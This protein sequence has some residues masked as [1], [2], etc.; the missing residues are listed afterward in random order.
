MSSQHS[1][2]LQENDTNFH[3]AVNFG[4]EHDKVD[5]ANLAKW[6][7]ITIVFVLILIATGFQLYT[8]YTY[9]TAEKQ[10]ISTTY[11]N[12]DTYKIQVNTR[13][14]SY[15]IADDSKKLYHIPIDK[16]IEITVNDY[17]KK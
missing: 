13:L 11:E 7:V 17:S 2:P 5:V 14:N 1:N 16:A 4:A 9:T 3:E 12:L 10:A 6:T 15:G 8:Y